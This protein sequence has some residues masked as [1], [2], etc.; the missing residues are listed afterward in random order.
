MLVVDGDILLFTIG[1]LTE[2]ITDFGDQICESFSK[3]DSLKLLEQGLDDIAELTGYDREDII[4]AISD[5]DNFRKRHFP[6]Y[7]S[8]RKEV[9]KP[10]GLLFLRSHLL[11]NHEKYQTLMLKEL[12]ADDAMGI[13]CTNANY[14][15]IYSQDKDLK[16]IP[17]RQWDFK[18]KKFITPTMHDSMTY[19]YTQV[20]T[21][22]TCDG[23]KGCPKIGKVKAAKA[24]AK[25]YTELD[26]L[27]KTH[28]L[29]Y[30][31]YGDNQL[32]KN[33]MLEQIGQAKILHG[34]DYQM[35]VQFDQTYNPYEVLKVTDE[36]LDRWVKENK[37]REE[38]EK[39][40]NKKRKKIR[41]KG[42]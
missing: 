36:Q 39:S 8:N 22:D 14:I 42:V 16:T 40:N 30:K 9:K 25:C 15:S 10:L 18:K 2:D 4:F 21:G 6:T 33:K 20:L 41:K 7:K 1:R 12:E 13:I 26:L 31:Y 37:L 32:A 27:E 3:E 5:Q 29:Y 23:Y 38:N 11:E 24:F 35:L 34:L 19:L 17:A 28:W